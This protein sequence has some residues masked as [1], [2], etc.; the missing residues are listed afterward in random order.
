FGIPNEFWVAPYLYWELAEYNNYVAK[1][2]VFTE[3]MQGITDIYINQNK[4]ED[5]TNPKQAKAGRA[6]DNGSLVTA[7]LGWLGLHYMDE[8]GK[9]WTCYTE[10]GK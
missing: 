2:P 6:R 1:D 3:W 10:T 9:P 5:F 8:I 7:I 4:W